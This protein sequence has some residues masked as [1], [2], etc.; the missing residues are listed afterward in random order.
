M[1]TYLSQKRVWILGLNV[2]IISILFSFAGL[3]EEIPVRHEFNIKMAGNEELNRPADVE[4]ANNGE[5]FVLDTVNNQIVVYD[6]QGSFLRKFGD[7][8]DDPGEFKTPLALAINNQDQIYVV[9]TENHR[10]Q[11]LDKDGKYLFEFGEEGS[12]KG[13]L[14]RPIGIT[15]G[16]Q[17]LV[18]VTDLKNHR[19]QVFTQKGKFICQIGEY[20]RDEGQFKYPVGLITD[21]ESNDL[22]V[23][24][25]LNFR[26]Q[27]FEQENKNTWKFDETFGQA[28]NKEGSFARPKD[29]AI[30][31]QGR[32]YITDSFLG[33]VQVL[34]DDGEFIFKIGGETKKPLFAQALGIFI[35]NRDN[36]LYVTDRGH[37]QIQVYKIT[38]VE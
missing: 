14:E 20:G 10:I 3:A 32:I 6:H 1:F 19:I 38:D 27:M 9:D 22:Y 5:I 26:V 11:V 7:Y 21:P 30:D 35:D 4:V 33:L 16:K 2:F 17:G 15:I 29:I 25:T 24:D 34:D 23:I 13:E 18:Y 37:N 31:N 36:R 28:G 8:G 12:A